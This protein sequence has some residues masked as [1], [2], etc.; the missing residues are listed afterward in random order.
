MP[1]LETTLPVL[2]TFTTCVL[3]LSSYPAINQVRKTGTV[4]SLN[5]LPLAAQFLQCN[6]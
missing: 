2:G 6:M 5:W 3:F 4:G 1:F